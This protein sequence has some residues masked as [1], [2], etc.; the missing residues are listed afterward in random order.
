MQAASHFLIV[1]CG[2]V[3]PEEA[4]ERALAARACAA[5]QARA[6][7]DHPFPQ[8]PRRAAAEHAA[9]AA[10]GREWHAQPVR[11]PPGAA[12]GVRQGWAAASR[13]HG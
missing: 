10:A 3:G 9:G 13:W 6:P 12:V 2:T 5:Q 7:Q 11:H 4:A 8:P 1:M